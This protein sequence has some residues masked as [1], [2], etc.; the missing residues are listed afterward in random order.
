MMLPIFI[1]RFTIRRE[2]EHFSEFKYSIRA[3]TA[4]KLTKRL[5][6]CFMGTNKLAINIP[7]LFLSLDD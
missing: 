1:N 7:K 2:K 3:G 4:F 5:R 6:E